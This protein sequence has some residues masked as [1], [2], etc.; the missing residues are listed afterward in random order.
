VAVLAVV[1]Y[2]AGVARV[3]GGFV[4]VDVFYVLSGF[5]ITGLLWEEL[6]ATGRLRMGAFYA[7]RAR[8]LLP[9]A[10]LVLT[11]TV[12]ASWAWLSPLQARLVA[13]DAAA[14]SRLATT[15]HRPQGTDL[16]GD[17]PCTPRERQGGQGL[18][19]WSS[20]PGQA[21][22]WRSV[23]PTTPLSAS[24]RVTVTIQI[25]CIDPSPL[26]E[27]QLA[28][29]ALERHGQAAAWP[30]SCSGVCGLLPGPTMGRNCRGLER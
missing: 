9:A 26:R 15:R 20:S 25:I 1:A 14:A 27:A 2:H 8:R 22:T 18:C 19:W 13:R 21:A 6:Q 28:W 7:R 17:G 29:L 12:A 5:L 4:G 10:V 3:E 23:S 24:T 30:R 11:V 16:T